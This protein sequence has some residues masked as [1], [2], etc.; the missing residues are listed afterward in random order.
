MTALG[1][2]IAA[3]IAAHGPISVADY[4]ARCL[5][6]P[7]H[8]YYTTRE[9]IGAKGDFTT[10]PEVSQ[11]FGELVAVWLC[12]VWRAQGAPLPAT[13][14]EV[15]P[16]RGTLMKDVLRTLRR[17]DPRLAAGADLAMVET[18]PRLAEVQR[19]TLG[20]EATRMRWYKQVD[21]LP[22][23]PLFLVANELLDAIPARQFVRA[24]DGWR[25]RMVGLGDDG[26]LHFVAGRLPMTG[27]VLP[28][29]AAS[30]P[31]GAILELA[32]ART[33]L[34]AGFAARIVRDGGAALLIDYGH[35]STGLGNTLQALRGHAFAD[36]LETPGEA[37][38]TTHVDF[39]P[40]ANEARRAGAS[41]AFTTQGEF[42]LAMGLVERAGA[43]G[44]EAG[45]EARQAIR[46]AVERL[47]GPDAMGNLFKVMAITPA[48]ADFPGFP[49]RID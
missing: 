24:P 15:G 17:L 13:L 43:L 46:G 37:D 10:A 19:G 20:A 41:A 12:S 49:G 5:Y 40:L 42:L 47:A 21:D 7:D 27:A 1:R 18:S 48:D 14:A 33:A 45:P 39:E 8:G 3:D 26:R 36:P 30:A 44:A 6:D 4:M 23:Q 28:V 16:G 22:A 38:L 25:E 31:P 9:P 34:V 32:P 29:A 11:M 35:L 2:R